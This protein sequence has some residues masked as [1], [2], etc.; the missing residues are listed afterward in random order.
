MPIS[1]SLAQSLALTAQACGASRDP[2]WVIGSA[3][4]ALAGLDDKEVADVDV[5]TSTAD[6]PRVAAALGATPPVGK[7]SGDHFRSCFFTTDATPLDIEVMGDLEVMSNGA[8]VPVRPRTRRAVDVAG[9]VIFIPDVAEQIEIL[10]LFGRPKDLARA[11]K[12]GAL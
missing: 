10:R 7:A 8:W 1:P 11:E 4:M 5:L 3:A 9:A 2:W 6:A 12:L